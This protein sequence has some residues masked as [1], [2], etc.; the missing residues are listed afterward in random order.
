MYLPGQ[1]RAARLQLHRSLDCLDALVPRSDGHME[2]GLEALIGFDQFCVLVR[3]SNRRRLYQ[4][5][6][7]PAMTA[8][9]L[10]YS[11]AFRQLSTGGSSQPAALAAPPC[12]PPRWQSSYPFGAMIN[13]VAS[14]APFKVCLL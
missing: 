7:L 4:L 10:K 2:R 12:W 9:R 1:C 8:H 3:H 13:I 6:P 14:A 5:A 11:H